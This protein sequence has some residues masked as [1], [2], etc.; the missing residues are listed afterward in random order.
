MKLGF[1]VMTEFL[2]Y[3]Q[4][5]TLLKLVEAAKA[6]G[7]TIVGIF[8]FGTGV[9][10]IQKNMILGRT[11]RNI[12]LALEA[13]TDVPM[14]ACQTWADNYAVFPDNIID[15]AEIAGLGELSNMTKEA[16]KII[17]FGAHA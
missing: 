17:T 4:I 2:K 1:T 16:D 7:H 14:W 3:E 6:K 15:G 9:L 10:N 13:L 11:T 8:F 12:P 5:Y